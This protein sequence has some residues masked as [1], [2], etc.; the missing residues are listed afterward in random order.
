VI[1][2]AERAADIIAGRAPL[3]AQDPADVAAA[4]EADTSVFSAA[5]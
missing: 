2:I 5:D 1:A 3:A 4:A